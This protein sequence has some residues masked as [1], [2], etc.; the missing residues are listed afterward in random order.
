MNPEIRERLLDLNPWLRSPARF[1]SEVERRMPE[2]FIPRQ[3]ELSGFEDTR[4]AKLV[5]GPRQ[6]GK[7]TLLWS[8]IRDRDPRSILFL[9]CEEPLVRKWARSAA[10]L[11]RD[12]EEE[13]P[14]VCT[15]FFEEAQHLEDAGL[16]LKGLVDAR[17]GLD[18]LVTGSSSFHLMDRTRESLAGRAERRVLLPF[19]LEEISAASPSPVPAVQR[20]RDLE[21][22]NRLMIIGGYPGVW[23]STDPH[24]ELRNLV[25]AFVLRDAS[26]RF[27]IRRLDAFR[28]LLQLAAGQ[29]GQMAN[30]SEWASTLGVAASTVREHLALL[31]ET[32]ILRLL[33]AFAGGRRREIT[34]T[35]RVQFLDMGLRNAVLNTFGEDL[36]RRPDRGALAEGFACGEIVKA[37]P[38][39][40]SL[41][42]WRSKGGAEVDFVLVQGQRLIA[43]EV[44]AGG[45][46][47]LTRSARSFIQAYSP[48]VFLMV[49]GEQASGEEAVGK[50]SI[51]YMGLAQLSRALREIIG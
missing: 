43:V 33:P 38:P 42:Y 29:I 1:L 21:I 3:V 2:V 50:T 46:G 6:A 11:L 4:R 14:S 13:F 35:P 27:R 32:W 10:G 22:T 45:R 34:S 5:V 31:E 39:S 44:K 37:L 51:R 41:H 16:L 36:A 40:W 7:S 8:L 18:V 19:S 17:A 26:D 9:N 48:E 28:R 15:A 12:L 20:A 47:R 25:E 24:H 49:T 23:S 30:Y